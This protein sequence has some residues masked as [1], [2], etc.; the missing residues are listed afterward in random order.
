MRYASPSIG[1]PFRNQT[2]LHWTTQTPDT[3]TQGRGVFSAPAREDHLTDRQPRGGSD[4][5]A[6]ETKVI[7]NVGCVSASAAVRR[8][9]AKP[10]RSV[11]NLIGVP[12]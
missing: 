5:P 2:G 10:T 7:Q 11:Q 6:A 8:P 3:D 12:I 1:A 9:A 4:G